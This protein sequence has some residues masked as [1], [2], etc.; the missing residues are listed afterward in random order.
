MGVFQDLTGQRFGRLLVTGP[1]TVLTKRSF[2]GCSCDCGN[3]VTIQAAHLSGGHTRSCGCLQTE[4]RHLSSITHGRSKTPEWFAWVGMMHRCRNPN[5]GSYGNYGG[6]GIKVCE[7][8]L[9]EQGFGNFFADLGTKPSA[10]HTLERIDNNGGY[11]PANCRWATRDEQSRNKRNTRLLTH[12]GETLC[13]G[14]WCRRLGLFRVTL[15]QLVDRGW[16]LKEIIAHD[17]KASKRR[18]IL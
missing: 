15:T 17:K 9:G 10:E 11:E 3:L 7:R 4:S 2:W 16:T 18:Q 1:F 8:W 12:D 5:N 13:I 6:R 14:E